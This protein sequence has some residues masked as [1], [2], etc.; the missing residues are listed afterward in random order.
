MQQQMGMQK[1][2]AMTNQTAA[3]AKAPM[4]DPT[5][6]PDAMNLINGQAGTEPPTA[7]QGQA[8]PPGF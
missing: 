6:N 2:M 8:P 3:L 5:K 4:F 1:E 7:G